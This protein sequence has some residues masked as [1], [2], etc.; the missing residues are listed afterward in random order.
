MNIWVKWLLHRH[1]HLDVWAAHPS[2][3]IR[4]TATQQK[5]CFASVNLSLMHFTQDIKVQ[6][7]VYSDKP[8]ELTIMWVNIVTMA[9]RGLPLIA[10]VNNGGQCAS[11]DSTQLPLM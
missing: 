2:Q 9:L 7:N 11:C 5:T 1:G 8:L 3:P 10:I 4:P 6:M